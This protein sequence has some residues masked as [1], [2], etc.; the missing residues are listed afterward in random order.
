MSG[1]KAVSSIKKY[2]CKCP[3]KLK[4]MGECLAE[5]LPK[6]PRQTEIETTDNN[7]QIDQNIPLADMKI[8]PLNPDPVDDLLLQSLNQIENENKEIQ[9]SKPK[10]VTTT[11]TNTLVQNNIINNIT[12]PTAQ[13]NNG[14][15]TI[16]Y[17]FSG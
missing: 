10:N 7:N 13:N 14:T 3:K 8:M 2:A 6:R 4:Q 5:G 12:N 17:N 9:P 1:H 15:V 16:N 11:P